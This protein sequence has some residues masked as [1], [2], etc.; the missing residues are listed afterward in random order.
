[1]LVHPLEEDK[2]CMKV[3]KRASN[4]IAKITGFMDWNTMKTVISATGTSVL[5]LQEWKWKEDDETRRV[6][7]RSEN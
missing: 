1:M 4:E 2:K 7:H 6:S 5:S 3:I